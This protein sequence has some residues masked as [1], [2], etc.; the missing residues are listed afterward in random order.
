MATMQDARSQS[1]AHRR[2]LK[3]RCVT[4]IEVYGDTNSTAA[5]WVARARGDGAGKPTVTGASLRISLPR[6]L[7]KLYMHGE[8]LP[9]DSPVPEEPPPLQRDCCKTCP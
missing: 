6:D 8:P 5:K 4:L 9:T 1:K 7:Q 3:L 2:V